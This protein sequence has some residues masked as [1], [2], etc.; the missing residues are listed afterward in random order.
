MYIAIGVNLD[1]R[2]D[3]LGMMDITKKWIGRCQDWR[4]IHT[5]LAIYFSE[6]MPEQHHCAQ[7]SRVNKTAYAALDICTHWRY[8]ATKAAAE[9]ACCRLK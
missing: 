1:G 5:Q 7:M 6:R 4:Q 2:K 3:V 9:Q 8:S